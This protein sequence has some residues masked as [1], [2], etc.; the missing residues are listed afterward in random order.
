MIVE[1]HPQPEEKAE[2]GTVPFTTKRG[3]SPFRTFLRAMLV[4]GVALVVIPRAEAEPITLNFE[5][6]DIKS[7]IG[8]V[9][10]QTGRNFV[11]DP[12]V[13]GEMT[14]ISQQ[15][16]DEEQL[17][18]VFLSALQI[19]GFAAVEGEGAIRIIPA[20]LARRDQVALVEPGAG[21][22]DYEVVTRAFPLEHVGAS[23]V[24]PVLRPLLD[25][26]AHL[27]AHSESNTLIISAAAGNVERLARII[28]RFDRD[29][30]GTTEVVELEH[31]NAREVVETVT[32]LEPEERAG[33]R[34]LIVADERGNNVLLGGDPRRRP[35]IRSLIRELDRGLEED[36]GS[37][38]VY[39]RYAEA[40]SMV[41]ILRGLAEDMSR[42]G[43]EGGE[44]RISI[45]DHES[46][47]AVVMD[48]PPDAVEKLRSVVHRL[49]VRRAQVLVEAIIAEVSSERL[50]ELG[51]QWGALGDPNIGLINFGA[52]GAGSVASVAEAAEAGTVP[53]V[54]GATA[55]IADSRG[56]V[57]M[58][59]RALSSD[60]EANVL[61]TPSI[62]TL[63][64]EEAEIIVGQNVPFVTGRAI[65]DSGQAFSS[66]QR[67]DVGVQLRIKPQINEGDALRLALEKE[68]SSVAP[69]PEGAQDLVTNMRSITTTAMVDDGQMIVLGGLMDEQVQTT[70]QSVPGL[71]RIPLVGRLFRYDR[72]TA[73]KHTLMVFLRPTIVKDAED[74]REITSPKYSLMRN[75]QLLRRAR[76]V[77]FLD[78]ELSPV[79]A[80]A[81]DLMRLPPAFDDRVGVRPAD[82]GDGIGLPP[83]LRHRE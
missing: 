79:L 2:K 30:H 67:E 42:A 64:N 46:T 41:P 3:L 48:G 22:P 16:L 15:P 47:N 24:V 18:Q 55:G 62:L 70:T 34:L 54:D 8:L 5:E 73:E 71:G 1:S 19:H 9:S 32:N 28:D 60:S 74:A 14:I 13:R 7:V 66:I 45:H 49:D 68:V 27:A 10:E 61:S 51:I 83:R 81:P 40:E 37:G 26:E 35:A 59:F 20:S 12:R 53:D 6:A 44:Q 31:A 25:D 43:G 38:V 78:D 29:T 76:G 72:T 58:L 56:E 39:L 11:I 23:E 63:D 4:F 57:G 52:A 33:R 50:R 75:R 17:Y 82:D 80:D 77:T 69:R 21:R 36:E 65:E